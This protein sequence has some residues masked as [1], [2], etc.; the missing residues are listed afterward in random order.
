MIWTQALCL[1]WRRCW[2]WAIRYQ[3][4]TWDCKCCCSCSRVFG[5]WTMEWCVMEQCHSLSW[6][7]CHGR[8]KPDLNPSTFV[9]LR[10]RDI[11]TE[12]YTALVTCSSRALQWVLPNKWQG[13]GY[14]VT[15]KYTAPFS[16]TIC[17]YR[18]QPLFITKHVIDIMF[19]LTAF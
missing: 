9:R 10:F 14:T 15:V 13:S 8:S 19:E 16:K 11:C 3:C 1:F 5:G 4:F 12:E 18:M 17:C 6:K 7:P 2:W